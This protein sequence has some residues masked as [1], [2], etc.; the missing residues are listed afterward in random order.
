M[1]EMSIHYKPVFFSVYELGVPAAPLATGTL[2]RLPHPSM[3]VHR[4]PPL[5]HHQKWLAGWTPIHMCGILASP[6]VQ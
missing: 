1:S 5:R 6:Y 4:M 2:H 3:Y